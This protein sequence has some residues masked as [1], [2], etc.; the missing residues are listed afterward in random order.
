MAKLTSDLCGSSHTKA[1][2]D[3][4]GL[5]ETED[6]VHRLGMRGGAQAWH[7]RPHSWKQLTSDQFKNKYRPIAGHN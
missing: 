3:S 7:Q 1:W 6:V 5:V 2:C 4:R